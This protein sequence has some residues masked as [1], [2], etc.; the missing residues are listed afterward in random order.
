MNKI[1]Q[2]ST[3]PTDHNNIIDTKQ[4][5]VTI[6]I[7]ISYLNPNKVKTEQQ[8][9]KAQRCSC[10]LLGRPSRH[11]RGDRRVRPTPALVVVVVRNWERVIFR[12]PWSSSWRYPAP[13]HQAVVVWP[14]QLCPKRHQ[15]ILRTYF[16]GGHRKRAKRIIIIPSRRVQRKKAHPKRKAKVARRLVFPRVNPL[17]IVSSINID[18]ASAFQF[19]F[20]YSIICSHRFLF[21]FLCYWEI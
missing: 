10:F 13:P 3:S 20:S 17:P 9:K 14:P 18:E 7:C 6:H 21:S 4:G 16:F 8:T 1:Y 19:L 12:S 11:D 2:K 5:T 15:E